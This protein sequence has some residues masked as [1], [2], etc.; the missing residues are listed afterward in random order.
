MTEE[1]QAEFQSDIDEY[2][3][4]YGEEDYQNLIRSYGSEDA[5]QYIY[6]N[7]YML[8]AMAEQLVD[9]PTTAELEQYISDNEVFSVK[10]ILLKTTTD[11]ITDDDGNVTQSAD[12]YNAAQKAQAEDLL[13]Q[14]QASDDMETL[15]DE[16]M[17]EYSEDGGLATNPDGY[18]YDSSA[19]LV[20]GFREAV[21][22]LE[23]GGLSDVV[24]T[25]YGY[26]IMLRLPVDAADFRDDWVSDQADAMITEA[27]EAAEVTLSENITALDLTSFY[28]RYVAYCSA[29]F[30]DESEES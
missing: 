25:S 28:E 15:F 12:D 21:L 14:L 19:S 5:F 1:Q 16:L 9:E 8:E 7:D 4:T 2:I 6:T 24:E 23:I 27:M 20:D 22:E 13:A 18:T 17:N 29:L 11:D 30:A 3:S 26:H 10:H